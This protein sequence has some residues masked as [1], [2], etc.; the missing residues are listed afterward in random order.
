MESGDSEDFESS[1]ESEEET[2]DW[3]DPD[4][5]ETDQNIPNPNDD[6]KAL[7]QEED[8]LPKLIRKEHFREGWLYSMTMIGEKDVT[9]LGMVVETKDDTF[10]FRVFA[11]KG[12]KRVNYHDGAKDKKYQYDK[13][14]RLAPRNELMLGRSVE[15]IRLGQTI[16]FDYD[17]GPYTIRVTSA[18]SREIVECGSHLVNQKFSRNL[19]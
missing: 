15:S 12:K 5:S 11:N 14:W 13:T 16:R 3:Y 19:K 4:E 18:I 9:L 7:F 17:D 8:K 6:P 2:S 1:H 10:L